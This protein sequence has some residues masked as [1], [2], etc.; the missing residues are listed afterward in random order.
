MSRVLILLPEQLG[1]SPDVPWWHVAQGKIVERGDDAGWIALSEPPAGR[2]MALAPGGAV[3]LDWSEPV[4]TTERQAA[5]VA[6]AAARESSPEPASMHT[7]AAVAGEGEARRVLTAS[8]SAAAIQGWLDWCRSWG[9]EPGAIVPSAL[10]LPMAEEWSDLRIGGEHLVGRA[11]LRFPYEPALAEAL[12]GDAPVRRMADKEVEAALVRAAE[13]PPLNLRQGRFALRRTWR[14]ERRRVRELALLAACIPLL[15]LVAALVT[16]V[17]LN[18]DSDRLD[19]EAAE[20]ASAALN[21]PVTP[22]TALAELDGQAVRTG[23]AGRGL[24]APL[25]ALYQYLQA[26]PAVT[27][28]GLGWRGD[29][30]LS[31]TLAAPRTEDINRLLLAMQRGGYRVTAVPRTGSDGRELAD[32]TLR[33]GA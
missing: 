9:R 8:V 32:V 18:R 22:E 6:A 11:E 3:R 29:G 23:I 33:S 4:G 2:L 20:V 17:R 10:L 30:T 7:V 12:I 28:T 15:A 26:E 24:S 1:A 14:L 13:R 25:S 5:A 21:R 31:T 27:A 16:I 19:R